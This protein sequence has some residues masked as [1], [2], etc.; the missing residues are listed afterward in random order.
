MPKNNDTNKNLNDIKKENDKVKVQLDTLMKQSKGYGLTTKEKIINPDITE[1]SLDNFGPNNI[2]GIEE[3]LFNAK[4]TDR[5]TGSKISDLMYA[6]MYSQDDKNFELEDLLKPRIVKNLEYNYILNNM[7]EMV[8]AI[9]TLSEDVVFPN[10]ALET[11]ITVKFSGNKDKSGERDADLIKFFRP[12]EDPLMSLRSRRLYNFD[13]EEMCKELVF[14]LAT[15]GY[16][17]AYTI[18]YKSIATDLLY[19]ANKDK[20]IMNKKNAMNNPTAN[21]PFRRIGESFYI[22]DEDKKAFAESF[23]DLYEKKSYKEEANIKENDNSSG[24]DNLST[25]M[26]SHTP[27]SIKDIDEVTRY[28]NSE[29]DNLFK[30]EYEKDLSAVKDTF[31]VGEGIGDNSFAN[32]LEDLKSKKQKKFIIDNIK[33]C[34]FE[35]LDINKCQPIFIK[36]ELIGVYMVEPIPEGTKYKLGNSLTNIINSSQIDDGLVLGDKYRKTI[37]EIVFKDLENVLRRNIDKSFLR[38][39][40]NLIEDIEWILD[41]QGLDNIMD[42]R[43]RFIPAE[44][45]TF[46]KHGPG[47]LGQSMLDKTKTYAMMHIQLNKAE[48]LNKVY[49]N[50]NRMKVSI[51]DTGSLDSQATIDRAIRTV[52]NA[53]PRLTDVGI[54]D[55]MTDSLLANYQTIIVQKNANGDE[56]FDV[57]TVPIAEPK[58]NSEYL[59]YLRNQATLG[60]GYPAD[61]LDPSQNLDFAKKISQIN[62]RTLSKIVSMQNSLT[63]PLSELCT[64]RIRYMTGLD[65]IEVEVEFSKPKELDDNTTLEGLEKVQRKVEMYELLI[66]NNVAIKDEEKIIMKAK[67]AKK[68]LSE[69]LDMDILNEMANDTIIEGTEL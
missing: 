65:G 28:I 69:Y 32:I 46:F 38:N 41:S 18:P 7:V 67:L 8:N 58:D 31:G 25:G 3:T 50:K 43:I 51:R 4:G 53:V 64:K 29:S 61:L 11:G 13:I 48:A 39:N 63:L 22:N 15:Y 24:L 60:L 47:L 62:L 35:F 14:N 19:Q 34:T 21:L 12:K 44:F 56:I 54:P 17:I 57:D 26:F 49:L 68:L 9:D 36:E 55:T 59:R 42:N 1:L 20:D 40:P 6:G 37:R 30:E 33:G 5:F 23:Y 2:N 45:L 10:S 52:R 16:Q 27:Y 66:D